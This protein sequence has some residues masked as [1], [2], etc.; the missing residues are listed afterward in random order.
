[1]HKFF[2]NIMCLIIEI[3]QTIVERVSFPFCYWK[4]AKNYSVICVLATCLEFKNFIL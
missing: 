2:K 4:T 3:Q 1:M